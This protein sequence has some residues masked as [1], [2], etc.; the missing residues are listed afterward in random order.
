MHR[1][2]RRVTHVTR[3]ALAC[4]LAA[5]VSPR[6]SLHAQQPER[7][8][9]RDRWADSARVLI[10]LATQRG[11][12][13]RIRS[14]RV[15]LDR[16]LTAFPNDPLLL[17]YLGFALYREGTLTIIDPTTR[18]E[19]APLFE[20]ARDTLARSRAS[21]DLPETAAL[22]YSVYGQLL[23]AQ[24][25]PGTAMQL[26]SKSS[27]ALA[28]ALAV[29]PRNPRVWLLRGIGTMFTPPAFGGGLDKAEEYLTRAVALFDTDSSAPPLPRWGHGEAYI[30]L[31]QVLMREGK[32]E[33]ARDAFAHATT[34]EPANDRARHLLAAADSASTRA[35]RP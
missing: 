2:T 25:D 34:L 21:L 16:A 33:A 31:G 32:R 13:V 1:I 29:G 14:A 3:F 9:G 8:T 11:D 17:H 5:N 20:A 35:A 24:P 30:W 10:D 19:A 23:G 7:L 15:L 28:H 26:G 12:V 27:A 4:A 6:H 18:R 22:E